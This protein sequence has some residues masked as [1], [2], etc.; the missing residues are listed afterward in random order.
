MVGYR[1]A[2][3][4]SP[5]LIAVVAVVG[6]LGAD[7]GLGVLMVT[8]LAQALAGAGQAEVVAVD[9]GRAHLHV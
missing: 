1:V 4:A 8:G 6:A 5:Q 3:G 2:A 9:A 7:I